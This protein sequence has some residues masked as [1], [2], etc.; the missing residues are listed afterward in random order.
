VKVYVELSN[1]I[2]VLMAVLDTRGSIDDKFNTSR[3]LHATIRIHN[4]N[5]RCDVIEVQAVVTH[6]CS[7]RRTHIPGHWQSHGQMPANPFHEVVM[8]SP[9][10]FQLYQYMR[11]NYRMS[12]IKE[13]VV[14]RARSDNTYEH[15][16]KS[17]YS[18][19]PKQ[20]FLQILHAT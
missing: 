8:I 19:G 10:M 11:R 15:G 3:R 20:S 9:H 1:W 6:Q 18:G 16:M 7:H 12:T 5:L 2:A 17:W 4:S 13:I 14:T